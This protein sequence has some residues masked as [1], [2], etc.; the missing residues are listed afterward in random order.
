MDS[1]HLMGLAVALGLGLLIGMQR[2]WKASGIAGVRT[3]ALVSLLGGVT[4]TLTPIVAPWAVAAGLVSVTTLLVLANLAKLSRSDDDIGLTTEVAA[5]LTFAIG[6][7][8]GQGFIIPAVVVGGATAVLLHW[9]QPIHSFIDSI[10]EK[11]FKGIAQLAL[12]GL[13]ILPILP[14][15]TYGPYD[16]LNPHRI[17]AMV[18]LIV[19]ISM[20]AYLAQRALGERVG[21]ILGGLLGGII[22]STAATVSYARQAAGKSTGIGM[23]ALMIVLAG[24]VVNLRALVEVAVVARPLLSYVTLP[25]VIMAAGMGLLCAL[26]Y[27]R[28]QND[29]IELTDP[30]NP[31]QLKVAMAFGLLYAVVLFA[32][33]V[34][35]THF[36][37]RALY[38]VA[39]ISGLTDIN[40]ITL[41]TAE[42]FN[43]NRLDGGTAWRI[44][45]VAILSN[46]VFKA[47]AVALLGSRTL[48]W[49]VFILFGLSLALGAALLVFWTDW[50]IHLPESPDSHTSQ[51]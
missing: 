29:E 11:D 33:A 37:D 20:S 45:L 40:A 15:E 41:S 4:A 43:Q 34:V 36:G 28:Y 3:F 24:T 12:I 19:G 16:V 8:A 22:S 39:A 26:T 6:A 25:L 13:V 10:G 48:T 9:K 42:L 5:L 38:G 49:R 27:Y 1:T 7:S 50:Q 17:W 47:G 31:A 30:K 51:Q 23:S 14:D 35:K 18:V 44:I 21:A 46:I 32:V 2:E